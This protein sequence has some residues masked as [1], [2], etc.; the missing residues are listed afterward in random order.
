[1]KKLLLALILVMM[2]VG[3][4]TAYPI[5]IDGQMYEATTVFQDD[6]AY[7]P[8]KWMANI[9]DAEVSWNGDAIIIKTANRPTVTGGDAMS[10]T[11]TYRAL[12]LL[13][14][15]DKPDY[16]LVCEVTKEIKITDINRVMK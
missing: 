6:H 4:A 8:L 13:R 2:M 9:F 7:L 5:N 3:T 16:K 15:K 14:D 1:M 10:R 11:Y 12:D